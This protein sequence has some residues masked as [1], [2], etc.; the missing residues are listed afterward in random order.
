MNM[1]DYSIIMPGQ[2]VEYFPEDQTATIRISNDMTYTTSTQD[3]EQVTPELLYDV[4][5]YT[6]GGG[7]WHIT[8]PIKAGDSCLLNFSQFGYDHW[9]INNEQSAGKDEHGS[10]QPWTRRMFNQA[11]GFAQV[12]WNNLPTKIADYS[13]TDSEWRNADRAQHISL[14]ED[15]NIH[16]K[17]GT[18]T[19]NLAPSG[20]ITVDT[21]T[22]VDITA[23]AEVSVTAPSV[24]ADC[25]TAVVTA[26][27]NI[28]LTTPVTNVSG[29]M[30]VGGA[31]NVTG[32]MN[33]AGGLAIAGGSGAA[34]TGSI[35]STAEVS[36]ATVVA[37]TVDLGSHMHPGDGGTGSGPNTGAPIP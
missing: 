27:A 2:V 12:G 23:G 13:S 14:L 28:D 22:S 16:I 1:N 3:E 19:I 24:V 15:G 10:P 29:I 25:A 35:S 21:D 11:D 4:P 33:G 36:G 31:L 6:S 37:G 20:A 18:T 32:L 34:V 30:N 5:V 26:S 9:F 17:T 7:N 8:F